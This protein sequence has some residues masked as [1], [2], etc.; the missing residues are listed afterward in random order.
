[1][2]DESSFILLWLQ[3]CVRTDVI[4][5]TLLYM[6]VRFLIFVPVRA[7]TTRKLV[8]WST[9]ILLY[10][11]WNNS[12][13][14]VLF[15]CSPVQNLK[16]VFSKYRLYIFIYSNT[17][18]VEIKSMQGFLDVFWTFTYAGIPPHLSIGW[19]LPLLHGTGKEG[20]NGC[21]LAIRLP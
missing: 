9:Q 17:A 20:R 21:C 7:P 8:L 14:S 16:Y 1:M 13:L 4:L 10:L 12:I 11:N 19:L 5:C 15:S 3:Y 2:Y 18:H 6:C